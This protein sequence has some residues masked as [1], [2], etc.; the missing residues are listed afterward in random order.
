MYSLEL[1]LHHDARFL[2]LPNSA[3]LAMVALNKLIQS[4]RT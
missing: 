3:E 1:G 4:Y 2:R